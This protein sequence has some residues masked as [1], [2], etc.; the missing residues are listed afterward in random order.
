MLPL[1]QQNLLMLPKPLQRPLISQPSW[2]IHGI[3]GTNLSKSF[4][5]SPLNSGRRLAARR[6][7]VGQKQICALL[8]ARAVRRERSRPV[9]ND[10]LM[11]WHCG[12]TDLQSGRVAR[13]SRRRAGANATQWTPSCS[14]TAALWMKVE[15]VGRGQ[16]QTSTVSF[17]CLATVGGL[18]CCP[19]SDERESRPSAWHCGWAAQLRLPCVGTS[20]KRTDSYRRHMQADHSL[21]IVWNNSY[22]ATVI[23]DDIACIIWIW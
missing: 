11:S 17:P 18:S 23:M 1:L 4:R 15:E 10:T 21:H 12:R 8:T 20:R 7:V 19:L 13:G 14:M 22:N 16:E 6:E 9:A 3:A 2:Q 5:S